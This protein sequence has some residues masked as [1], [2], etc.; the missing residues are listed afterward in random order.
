MFRCG[1]DDRRHHE[2]NGVFN[3]SPAITRTMPVIDQNGAAC[4]GLSGR[5][6]RAPVDLSMVYPQDAFRPSLFDIV[7]GG[8]GGDFVPHVK[9]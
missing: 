9:P 2:G 8:C 6:F 3:G 7:V 1:E 5:G 4:P